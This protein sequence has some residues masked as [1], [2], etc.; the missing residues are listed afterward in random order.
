[1]VK[2]IKSPYSRPIR[3]QGPRCVL[4]RALWAPENYS[5]SPS[6]SQRRS[7]KLQNYAMYDIPSRNKS[8]FFSRVCEHTVTLSLTSIFNMTSGLGH[9]IVGYIV[10]GSICQPCMTQQQVRMIFSWNVL[11]FLEQILFKNLFTVFESINAK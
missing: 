2:V 7:R 5:S 4:V 1:M 9:V 10:G 3:Y 6:L 11:H 8:V